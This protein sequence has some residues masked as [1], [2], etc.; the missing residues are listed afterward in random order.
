MYEFVRDCSVEIKFC[1]AP[2]AFTVE[3]I[4]VNISIAVYIYA[5]TVIIN[6]LFALQLV[7]LL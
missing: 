1:I 6:V 3:I 4:L 2:C 7:V 5:Q